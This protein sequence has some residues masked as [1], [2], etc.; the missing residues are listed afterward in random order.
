LLSFESAYAMIPTHENAER[1][2]DIM[3]RVE[4]L[5]VSLNARDEVLVAEYHKIRASQGTKVP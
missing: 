3:E 5:V 4:K 2:I 1:L